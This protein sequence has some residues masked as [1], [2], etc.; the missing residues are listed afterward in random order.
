MKLGLVAHSAVFKAESWQVSGAV[1]RA[2]APGFQKEG[3]DHVG[4]QGPTQLLR[5]LWAR[6]Q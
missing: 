3:R 6:L 1:A 4:E 2:Q 5:S